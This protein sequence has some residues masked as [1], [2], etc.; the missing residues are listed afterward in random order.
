MK[1]MS[2]ISK[3]MC[4]SATVCGVDMFK[5]CAYV[6]DTSAPVFRYYLNLIQGNLQVRIYMYMYCIHVPLTSSPVD[7]AEL[8]FPS[9]WCVP[10]MHDQYYRTKICIMHVLRHQPQS[11]IYVYTCLLIEVSALPI[12]MVI[13][14]MM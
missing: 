11:H 7:Q 6:G 10:T 12:V 8:F 14:C 3:Q 13:W 4:E 9:Y 2:S 5:A 1:A